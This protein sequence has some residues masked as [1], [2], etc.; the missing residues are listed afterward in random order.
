MTLNKPS[1]ALVY[2][3]AKALVKYP[4]SAKMRKGQL[5]VT[6]VCSRLARL[7]IQA[8]PK[9]VTEVMNTLFTQTGDIYFFFA[10]RR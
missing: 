7:G 2:D 9:H 3:A 10:P 8:D 4:E 1:E 5:F 6:D